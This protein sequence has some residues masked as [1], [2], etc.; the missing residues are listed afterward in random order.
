MTT[1]YI[2]KNGTKHW[3]VMARVVAER[4]GGQVIFKR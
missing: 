2:D 3:G 4:E 1:T